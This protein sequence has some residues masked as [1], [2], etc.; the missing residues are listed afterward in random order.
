MDVDGASV[1]D[2]VGDHLDAAM[3]E[4]ESDEVRYH[5]REVR[6]LLIAFGE[7]KALST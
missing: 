4:S 7:C 6:Q 3:E 2:E 5:L 1:L